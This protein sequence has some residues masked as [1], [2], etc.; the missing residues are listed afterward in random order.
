MFLELRTHHYP[1]LLLAPIHYS[2]SP[3]N[4]TQE[5]PEM[6]GGTNN[7]DKNQVEEGDEP[8]KNQ[9]LCPGHDRNLYR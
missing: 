6:Q 2:P 1:V 7:R 3:T 5:M 9:K 4:S 8:A